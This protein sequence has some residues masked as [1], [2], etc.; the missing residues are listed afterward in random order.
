MTGEA[1]RDTLARLRLT[2][3]EAAELLGVHRQSV[4]LWTTGERAVPEYIARLLRLV[5]HIGIDKARRILKACPACVP[6]RDG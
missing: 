1:F 4:W 5:E 2:R 3:P 6:S